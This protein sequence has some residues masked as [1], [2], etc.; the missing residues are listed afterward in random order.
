MAILLGFCVLILQKGTMLHRRIGVAYW[1]AMLGLNATALAIYDLF[2]QWGPFHSL[3]VVSL[4]SLAAGGAAVWA[5][6]PRGGW[7][8][9]HATCMA[10]SFAGVLAA[11][12][13]E[14]GARIPGVG[15]AAGVM[16]PTAAVMLAAA[17]LIHTRV[18]RIV[19]RLGTPAA[20]IEALS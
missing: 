20:K 4:L 16:W 10:W 15:L 8:R 6:R 3:A 12:F 19:A 7:M 5:R 14:I 13:S 2:G 11:F 1:L 17:I 18:P 9:L